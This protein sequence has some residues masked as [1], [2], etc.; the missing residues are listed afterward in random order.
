MKVIY[1]SRTFFTDCDFPLVK[2][3]Q[4]K[5]VDVRYYLPLRWN[6]QSNCLLDLEH[7]IRKWGIYK[8]SSIPEM[9]AYKNCLDLKRLYLICGFVSRWWFP[10][11][12]LLYLLVMIHMFFQRA[13]VFHFT[14]QFYS[15]E[16]I[17]FLL[18]FKKVIMTVHDPVQHSGLA[19][20]DKNEKSRLVCF[21]KTDTFLL[22]NKKSVD[23]FSRSYG[24][25]KTRIK[26]SHLGAYNAIAH[27]DITNFETVPK[28]YIIFFGQ[29]TPHKG[30][31]YL[32]EA[33]VKIHDEFPELKLLVAGS[34][35]LYFDITPY[36]NLDYIIVKNYYI[37]LRSLVNMVKNS[38][39]TVCPY[40]DATQSGVVQ[41]ALALN[42]P[43]ITT[44]V[45]A[46]PDMINDGK[47]G[48]VVPSCDSNALSEEI[49][50]LMRDPHIIDEIKKRIK[51][52]WEPSMSWSPIAD[53]YIALYET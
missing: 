32:L 52:D 6:F 22:L 39:I 20:H 21:G 11:S 13:D 38:I 35:N 23:G 53:D 14:W 5:N 9:Q 45:G 51:E 16:R 18:P 1:Y 4:D 49:K 24:I 29:I 3:L 47:Y 48:R 28:P 33:M 41:T 7:P 17:L 50:R 25:D 34:G 31:E 2:A 26:E 8:A 10:L 37:G 19:N 30:L 15:F 12:W 42:I 46:L 43:V 27:I 36:T 40:K 44:N